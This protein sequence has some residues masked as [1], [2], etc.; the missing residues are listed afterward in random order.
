[1]SGLRDAVFNDGITLGAHGF[2]N[3][4]INIL[5]EAAYSKGSFA[6]ALSQ[7]DDY[8]SYSG[9]VRAHFALV[10]DWATYVDYLYYYYRFDNTLALPNAFPSAMT[11]NSIRVGFTLWVP[12][13]RH[14]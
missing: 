11:R 2:V 3:Q 13:M 7:G 8:T 4:R 10:R 12:I 1:M 14:R 5:A 9:N 6:R